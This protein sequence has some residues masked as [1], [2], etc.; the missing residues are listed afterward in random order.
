MGKNIDNKDNSTD[1]TI[2]VLHDSLAYSMNVQNSKSKTGISHKIIDVIT[3]KEVAQDMINCLWSAIKNEVDPSWV[4]VDI[5]CKSGVFLQSLRNILYF[6]SDWCSIERISLA[7]EKYNNKLSVET[8]EI[9][10]KQLLRKLELLNE[11]ESNN[12]SNYSNKED[13]IFSHMLMGICPTNDIAAACKINLYGFNWY[14]G[15]IAFDSNSLY[16][17]EKQLLKNGRLTEYNVER[18]ESLGNYILSFYSYLKNLKEN[19]GMTIDVIVGNPPYQE[20]NSTSGRQSK[21][22]YD[23]FILM[24]I[25]LRPNYITMITN[26]TFLCNDSKADLRDSMIKAGLKHM[27]NYPIS[28]E[29]FDGVG[30][31]ACTFLIDN[32]NRESEFTY[33]R[34]E[35]S[36]V[37]NSYKTIINIGDIIPESK[38]ELTIPNKVHCK[39]TMANVILGDKAF[40]IASSGKIGFTGKGEMI[41]ATYID[42]DGSIK[43]KNKIS[44]DNPETMFMRREDVPKGAEYIDKYKVICP[45]IISKQSLE[46]FNKAEILMPGWICTQNWSV[47]G[48]FDNIEKA[49]NLTKYMKTKVF[50]VIAFIYASNAMTSLT[51][52]LMSHIPLQDFSNDSDIDWSQ[53]ISDIDNQLYKKYNLTDDEIDYIENTI[54]AM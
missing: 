21:P 3:P 18:L 47:I 37:V 43:L 6:D 8:N 12:I 10:R 39:D 46:A 38:Y 41:E 48:T 44:K 7:R 14:D 22:I 36:V 16:S 15:I 53:P 17:H 5:Y 25:D 24:A 52:I 26:N 33:K 42:F 45:L 20:N 11:A 27:T 4:F 34:I 54:K 23:K 19:Q 13:W 9:R 35:N 31:S 50:K 32:S 51:K 1:K 28:G 2:E 30:V 29:I 40:G 49:L